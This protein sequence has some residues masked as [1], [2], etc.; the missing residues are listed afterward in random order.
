MLRDGKTLSPC[1]SP[2]VG[3]ATLFH[4]YVRQQIAG[5][6][7][8]H[9]GQICRSRTMSQPST[10]ADGPKHSQKPMIDKPNN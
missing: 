10:G 6:G 9:S 4:N 2:G 1:V 8:R 5:I 7:E 3:S